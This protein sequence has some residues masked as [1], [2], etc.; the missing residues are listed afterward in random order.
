M[1]VHDERIY[2]GD[3]GRVYCG[4][5]LGATAKAT[6]RDLSGQPI[7]AVDRRMEQEF[8]GGASLM[9]ERCG[10]VTA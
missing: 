1:V 6:G 8:L 4:A 7:L 9:C 3:N 5:H 2:L 10:K